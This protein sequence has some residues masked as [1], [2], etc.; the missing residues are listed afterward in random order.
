MVLMRQAIRVAALVS[1]EP[2]TI[3]QTCNR[4]LLAESENRFASAFIGVLDP[5]TRVLRYV[6]AGH[7]PPLLRL[8]T[9]E[10]RRLEEPSLPLGAF[11]D[12]PFETHELYCQDGAMLVLYTDGLIEISR[13]VIEGARTLEDVVRSD[14]VAH[15]ANPAEFIERAIA[16]QAPRDDIA[17]LA[18]SF[19]EPEMRWQFEAADA[20]AAYTMRDEFFRRLREVC[21]PKDEELCTCGL[22]FAELVGNAVRHAPGPLS[23]SLEFRGADAVLHIIDKGPGFRY[24]PVLPENLWAEG[25]RGLFLVSSLA[26]KV[27]VEQLPGLGSHVIVTLPVHCETGTQAA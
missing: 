8:S 24:D 5:Q 26:R 19:S 15:A 16:H 10:V 12:A 6:S 23:I 13:D 20:R 14:A 17:I 3:A 22:I 7:A 27:Q 4:L 9:K 21:T 11:R 2:K 18:V 1:P 25:G